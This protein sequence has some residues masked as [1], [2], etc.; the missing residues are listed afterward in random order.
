MSLRW[1]NK[2]LWAEGMFLRTQHFQQ[3]ERYLE[4]LVRT[5]AQ[6]LRPLSWGFIELEIDAPLLNTGVFALSRARGMLPD[7]TPFDIPGD[8][9]HPA[10]LAAPADLRGAVLHLALPVRR[11][12]ATAASLAR[13]DDQLLRWTGEEVEV[14]DTLDRGSGTAPVTVGKLDLR[15]MHDRQELQGF[16]TLPLARLVEKRLDGS[17][18]LDPA[19]APTVLACSASPVLTSWQSEIR[20]LLQHRGQAIAARLSSPGGKGSAEITDFLVLMLVNR[21]EMTLRHL[22]NLPLLHPE[23]LYGAFAGLAGELATFTESATNR[24]PELPPYRHGDLQASFDP[25]MAFLREALSAVFE[26]TAIPIPL[27]ERAYNIRVAKITDRSL[28]TD[29]VFVLAAKSTVDPE[30]LRANLPKRTTIGPV[31]RIRD[32]VNLQLGGAPIRALPTEPRQIPFRAGTVYFEINA[33]SEDWKLVE[34]SG[35]AALHVS[36]DVPDLQL[37]MWAIRGRIR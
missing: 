16:V 34:R 30:T 6:A 29:C 18:Q 33:N 13:S 22:A 11:P 4:K 28:F 32:L 31:E 5:G 7:G 36:G 20:G 37:E 26:Q 25:L 1:E 15:L 12:G 3:S 14:A 23:T 8:D 10:P 35:G 21:N 24:P 27:E 9:D 2:V 19:F 17:L